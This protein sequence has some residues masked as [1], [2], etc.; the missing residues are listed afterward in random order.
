MNVFQDDA[1]AATIGGLSIENG[2][3][4]VKIF[5][6]LIVRKDKVSQRQVEILEQHVQAL[7]AFLKAQSDLPE[8]AAKGPVAPV[9]IVANPFG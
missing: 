3:D 1:A 4:T 8:E 5:G 6:E 9:E 2:T 7:T